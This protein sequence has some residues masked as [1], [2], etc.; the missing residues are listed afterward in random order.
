MAE[1]FGNFGRSTLDGAVT[2][3][4]TSWVVADGSKF[5]ASGNFRVSCEAEI[6]LC[7]ARSGNTLTITRAQE[8]TTNVAH[9]DEALVRHSITAASLDNAIDER[10][11]THAAETSGS[12]FPAQPAY[13]N[14]R[15]FYR[16][17][18][19]MEF[20]YDGTRWLSTQI[21]EVNVSVVV[22]QAATAA[23]AYF[24][25]PISDLDVWAIEWR[26]TVFVSTTNDAS[27]YWTIHV[28]KSNTSAG[29]DTSIGNFTTQSL[30][31]GTELAAVAAIGAV[32][33]VSVTPGGYVYA[34]K[35]STPG[36]VTPRGKFRYRY[37]AT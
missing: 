20:Y 22:G 28:Y 17:D 19:G 3:V 11:A 18:L 34:A 25:F 1:L 29:G 31:A 9:A 10:V 32:I 21:F 15:P 37:I 4:A 12:S 26:G 24:G 13:G 2:D 30:S 23:I 33:D 35:T 36:N 16:T 14:D 7:T 27:K 6:A 5:P 8:G